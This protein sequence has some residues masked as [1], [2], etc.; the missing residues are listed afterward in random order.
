APAG[1]GRPPTPTSR[2]A[3]R[4]A[5]APNAQPPSGAPDPSAEG[6]AMATRRSEHEF[7][8]AP[9]GGPGRGSTIELGAV[10]ARFGDAAVAAAAPKVAAAA[11]QVAAGPRTE[12]VDVP[13]DK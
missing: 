6:P 4:D 12:P 1:G 10:G 11:P 5:S 2:G 8:G 3:G 13:S 7:A 9:A